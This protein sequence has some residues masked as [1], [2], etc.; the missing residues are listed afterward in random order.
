M[1][2]RQTEMVPSE[3]ARTVVESHPC[4]QNAQGWGTHV[5]PISCT[6]F[7]ASTFLRPLPCVP[8]ASNSSG[9]DFV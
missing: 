6:H 9:D 8:F 3:M 7:L 5:H 1:T 2:G 4:A